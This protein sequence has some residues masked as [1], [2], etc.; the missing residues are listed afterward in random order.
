MSLPPNAFWAGFIFGPQALQSSE[1]L[2]SIPWWVWLVIMVAVLVILVIGLFGQ[3]RR[4]I[5]YPGTQQVLP[6]ITHDQ[7]STGTE[8]ESTLTAG[9]ASTE[10]S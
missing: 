5:R 2:V 6:E 10:D 9:S 8:L 1:K 7:M 3:E 4:D